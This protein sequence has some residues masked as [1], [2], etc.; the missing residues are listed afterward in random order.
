MLKDT[1]TC[2]IQL[3]LPSPLI[4][5][6]YHLGIHRLIDNNKPLKL[7]VDERI[8]LMRRTAHMLMDVGLHGNGLNPAAAIKIIDT[9]VMPRAL[10][11][12]AAVIISKEDETKLNQAHRSL[13][14]EVQSLPRNTAKEAI[15][16]LSG[17]LPISADLDQRRLTLFGT[18][19]RMPGNPLHNIAS[20]QVALGCPNPHSFFTQAVTL[21]KKYGIDVEGNL[22]YP[23]EKDNWKREIKTKIKS[24]HQQALLTSAASKTSLKKLDLLSINQEIPA[25]HPIWLNCGNDR[26]SIHKS[27]YRAKMLSGG[28]LLQSTL[29]KSSKGSPTCLLCQDEE[30]DMTHFVWRCR[31]LSEARKLDIP[32][33]Q[34]ALQTLGQTLPSNDAD[35][36]STILNGHPL[37]A[38]SID[39]HT[40]GSFS[41]AHGYTSGIDTSDS[42]RSDSCTITLARRDSLITRLNKLCSSVCTKLHECRSTILAE[43]GASEDRGILQ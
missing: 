7:C 18:V 20:R 15:Y 28:Y 14:R 30:E 12:L 8:S 26:A 17:C 2:S 36:T 23:V 19:T 13:I 27:N 32:K 11:G 16:L 31:A 37:A 29:A 4:R 9:Y 25:P 40:N 39:S 41:F 22:M 24:Y 21:G 6:R 38:P 43:P 10:Y 1:D 34:E 33:I 3:N 5:T 35:W 42:S